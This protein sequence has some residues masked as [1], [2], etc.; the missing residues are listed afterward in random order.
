MGEERRG[1]GVSGREMK[2]LSSWQPKQGNATVMYY[3]NHN[4]C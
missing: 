1:G 3:D 2:L 4:H